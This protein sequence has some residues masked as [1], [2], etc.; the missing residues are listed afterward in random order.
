MYLVNN[1]NQIHKLFNKFKKRF[2]YNIDK[3]EYNFIHFYCFTVCFLELT[4][5]RIRILFLSSSDEEIK[6]NICLW[7]LL[8]LA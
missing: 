4:T 2:F 1:I 8:F 5:M 3:R 6:T 7:I